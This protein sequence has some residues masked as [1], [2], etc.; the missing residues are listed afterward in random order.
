MERQLAFRQARREYRRKS[1]AKYG[2]Q[3]V[4]SEGFEDR[5]RWLRIAAVVL[6]QTYIKSLKAA[7]ASSPRPPAYLRADWQMPTER[8]FEERVANLQLRMPEVEAAIIEE[9]LRT[10]RGHAGYAASALLSHQP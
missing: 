5:T 4:I 6:L 8:E 7:E 2:G 10:Y 9:S 1:L 3:L